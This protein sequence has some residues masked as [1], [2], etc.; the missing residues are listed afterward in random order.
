MLNSS[1]PDPELLK[2]VLE[3]LLD[4][5]EY[6]FGRGRTLLETENITFLT[7]QE[8]TELLERVQLAQ[9]EVQATQTL[10]QATG[11]QVGIDM[12]ILVP[13]HNLVTQCWQ[14]AIKLRQSNQE[15]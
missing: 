11:G 9:K 2:V 10:F 14:V 4:D 1:L 13:W 5:F 15:S 12:E 8:R 6:W 7:A 3:P